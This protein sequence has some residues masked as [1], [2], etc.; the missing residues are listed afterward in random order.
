M[1]GKKKVI[2][3]L[4]VGP[5][6]DFYVAE[7]PQSVAKEYGIADKDYIETKKRARPTQDENRRMA[8]LD[9]LVMPDEVLKAMNVKEEQIAKIREVGEKAIDGGVDPV[10]DARSKSKPDGIEMLILGAAAYWDKYA[11]GELKEVGS[12]WKQLG[13]KYKEDLSAKKEKEEAT[14]ENDDAD[15]KQSLHRTKKDRG[16]HKEDKS[17]DEDDH[18]RSARSDRQHDVMAEEDLQEEPKGKK[19]RK[20][21]L[22]DADLEEMEQ[23]G[24]SDRPRTRLAGGKLQRQVETDVSESASR[25]L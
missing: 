10:K 14:R 25:N 18:P 3:K 19:D 2:S 11:S 5:I 24:A 13:E 15:D 4:P 8:L 1:K 21:K 16:S 12:L 17:D 9:L 23:G 22:E 7:L 20:E 6:R